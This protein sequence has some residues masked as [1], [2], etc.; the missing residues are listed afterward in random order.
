MYKIFLDDSSFI[1]ADDDYTL[2]LFRFGYKV[3][4]R[5]KDYLIKSEYRKYYL[6]DNINGKKVKRKITKV[7]DI[8]ESEFP[9]GAR[10]KLAKDIKYN[11]LVLGKDGQPRRVKELHTG[12]DEM[13][14]ITVDGTSY[15]VNGGH[16]LAL[17]NKETGEHLEM[18]VNIYMHMDDDFKSYYVMEKVINE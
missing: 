15:T 18:P 6:L 9:V 5:M 8:K 1:I 17:V 3:M 14:E 11:D 16:I 13:F 10:I 7:E 12:E 2:T 4:V